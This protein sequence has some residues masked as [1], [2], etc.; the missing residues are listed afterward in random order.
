MA[1]LEGFG[2]FPEY[3][4]HIKN[5]CST[6]QGLTAFTVSKL[7]SLGEYEKNAG[8]HIVIGRHNKIPEG[9]DDGKDVFLMGDC[10]HGLKKKLGRAVIKCYWTW[11]VPSR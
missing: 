9:V 7:K 10:T 8:V 11:G 2:A 6:C 3:H 1:Y 5:A 4:F